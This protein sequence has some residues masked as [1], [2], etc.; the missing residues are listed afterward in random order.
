MTRLCVPLT[1]DT[2]KRMAADIRVAA[3]AGAEMIELRLDYLRDHDE[4]AIRQLMTVAGEF[5]GAVVATCRLAEEGGRYNDDESRRIALMEKIAVEGADYLDFEYEAWQRS[6]EVRQ[7]I[8]AV[9]QEKA[10]QDRAPT[11]LILSKHD[12][13]RTPADLGKLFEDLAREPC[14]VV[15]LTA[16]AER[17]TDALV[18]LDALRASATKHPTIALSMGETGVLTRVLAKKFGALLTFASLETGKESAP[19]QLTIDEM[20]SLYRW[21]K[22]NTQ[23]RVYGVIGCPVAHSMSPAILNAAFKAADYDGIYLPMRVEPDYTDFEAFVDGCISRPWFGFGGCSVTIPHKR[24][25]LQFVEQRGGEIEPLARRIGA[26]NTLCVEPGRRE[27]GSDAQV[28][29][30]NTD[31]RGAMDALCAGMDTSEAGLSG[32]KVAVLGAGGVSRAIA[33]GLCDCGCRVTIY[34]RTVGKAQ[35]LA[36]EFGATARP[37]EQRNAIEADVVINCTSIGMWPGT[38]NSPLPDVRLSART[39]VF[40]TVYNPVDTRLLRDA[41]ERGCR[42]IDGVAMFVNQAAAQFARWTGQSAP[43]DVMRDVV[44]GRLSQRKE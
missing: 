14:H 8:G 23:T 17:I 13:E 3:R 34:N 4:A 20:R 21:D 9:C 19:G 18:M 30:Y 39:V 15:K 5:P 35:R 38:D 32:S 16:R 33:A 29:A 26:A 40:D 41:R 27:D 11:R 2:V 24:N 6:A 10:D 1:A 42:T 37:W 44:V 7:R 43:I 12:F 22:L 28:A 36:E 25:L 31:Y